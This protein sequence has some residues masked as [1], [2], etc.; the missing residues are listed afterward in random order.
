MASIG[1]GGTITGTG[2]Y[3]KDVSSGAVRVIG[4]NPAGS[5]YGGGEDGPIGIEG[6]GTRWPRHH[7]PRNFDASVPDEIRSVPDDVAFAVTRRLAAEEGLL[8]GPSSGLAVAVALDVAKD[9]GPEA[10]VVAMAPD[11]GGNYL[12]ALAPSEGTIRA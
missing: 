5:T 12:S 7:W 4:A 9:L 11:G 1:T 10:V 3:L 6:V 2:R 8:L